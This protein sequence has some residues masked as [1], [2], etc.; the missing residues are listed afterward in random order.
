M[1]LL[2]LHIVGSV[3][4]LLYG[5]RLAAQGFELAF[6]ASI[7][8]A[9]SAARDGRARAFLLGAASAAVLQSTGA[10]VTLF[11]TF[12][13]VA[14]PPLSRSLVIILGADFG[15]TLTVQLLSF[16]IHE[17]AFPVLSVGVALF[18]WGGKSRAHA[19]GQGLLGFGFVLLSLKFL[20]GAAEEVGRIEG[21]RI[22]MTELSSAPYTAFGAGVLL[23]AALQSGTAVMVLLIAFAH[24]GLLGTGAILPLVLGA[25]VGGTSVAFV[26]ASGLAAEGKRI[27]WG[28]FGIKAAGALLLLVPLVHAPPAITGLMGGGARLVASAHTAF[29][30]FIAVLFLPLA[31]RTA[32]LIERAIPLPA[33]SV[34]RGRAVYLDR[35]HL[36]VAGAALGQ[37]AREI[38]RMADMIQEML[39]DAVEVICRGN[40]ERIGRIEQADDDVDALSREIKG[41]LADL[42]Q[43]SLDA[44]QTERSMEY[45]GVVADLKNIGDFVDR[46]M[47][48]HLRR[49]S[50][51]RQSFSEE[52]GRELQA[53]LS[54][55]GS[56]Y[57]EAVSAFVARDPAAARL[58]MERRKAIGLR[59]RELRIAH[60]QRLQRATPD[61]LETS[62]AHMDIL[63]NWKGIAAHC[64]AIARTVLR[65]GE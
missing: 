48:D 41:F 53:Y 4:L 55:V 6:S 38:L 36:P 54:E 45:I 22:L 39:D 9:W 16:R 30:L 46:T 33:G 35:R 19:V 44:A 56:L 1:D 26:A 12:G 40:A 27:A 60:I 32:S 51:R 29:N 24:E 47:I 23:A 37:V 7:D 65:G 18:L 2:F 14:M 11:I 28:H 62:E 13:Q 43:G 21:L 52:G 3:F 49:L 50:E 8:R 15:A 20:A 25:N 64:S 58:V 61:S 59:E 5:I 34:S 63:A 31:G 10:F 42:G 57:R 17:L